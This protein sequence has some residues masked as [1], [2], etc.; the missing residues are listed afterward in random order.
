MTTKT[1]LALNGALRGGDGNTGHALAHAVR[2]VPAD[3]A[4]TTVSLCDWTGTTDDL[5]ARVDRA[6]GLLLATGTYWSSWGSPL[7]RF[8]EVLTPHEA[9]PVLLGKPVAAVVTMDSVG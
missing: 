9:S 5:V 2:M 4:V 6:D 8:L 3:V 7:Q 1:L